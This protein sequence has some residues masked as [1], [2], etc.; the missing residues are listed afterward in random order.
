MSRGG[1]VDEEALAKALREGNLA[2]A[3]MDAFLAEPLQAESELWELDNLIL[4]PHIA[5]GCQFEG[6]TLMEIFAENL[7]KFLRGESPLHNQVDKEK[8][9]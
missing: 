8:Q 3:A 5:G 7:G 9:Y 1:I 6:D 4:T 2:A